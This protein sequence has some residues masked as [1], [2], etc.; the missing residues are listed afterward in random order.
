MAEISSEQCDVIIALL[1]KLVT[2]ASDEDV[3]VTLATAGMKTPDIA[4]ILGMKPNTIAKRV[5][6]SGEKS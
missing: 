6:R 3:V 2:A 1:A 5:A 4:R